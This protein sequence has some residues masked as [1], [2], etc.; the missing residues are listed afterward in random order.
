MR[1]WLL[2][3]LFAGLL[4]STAL[5][6][7]RNI[8][9]T[10]TMGSFERGIGAEYRGSVAAANAA[11]LDDKDLNR[12][13]TVLAPA[14]QYCDE[15]QIPDRVAVSVA[16]TE[17]YDHFMATHHDG[18]PVEWL[19]QAC[20]AAY[21]AAAFIDIERKNYEAGMAM[22]AK[23]IAIAPYSPEPLT[24][25]GFVLNQTGKY[26]DALIVYRKAYDLA[27]TFVSARYMKAIALRGIGYSLV[28]L[29][30]LAGAKAAYEHALEVEPDNATALQEL[31]YI[32]KRLPAVSR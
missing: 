21:K 16:S 14:L 30:D 26:Q 24:E 19:D 22:L 13:A 17:E 15:Q 11:A 9:I 7:Q 2:G 23:A 32:H 25:Q 6:A 28:E 3:F 8:V 10:K 4:F 1:T 5:M 27:D 20:P 31:D 12:A 18:V 29:N